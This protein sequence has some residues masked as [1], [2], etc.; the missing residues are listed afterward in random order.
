MVAL[1]ILIWLLATVAVGVPASF[2]LRRLDAVEIEEVIDP[3]E[4]HEAMGRHPSR[5]KVA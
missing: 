5:S 4:L 1:A 2:L 3:V